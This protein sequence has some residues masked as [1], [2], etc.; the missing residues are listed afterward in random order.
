MLTLL[1]ARHGNTFDKGDIIRRVGK[2]TDLPLSQSGQLQAEQLGL[3]LKLRFA[4]IAAV[5][6]STLIRTI[7][8][9]EL[10]LK[11]MAHRCPVNNLA[12]FD[13]VDYGPDEGK[14]ESEVIARVGEQALKDWE[15]HHVVPDGWLVDPQQINRQW[16]QFIDSI[17]CEYDNKTV[18]VITSNGNARFAPD[19]A[20][21][22]STG[23]LSHLQIEKGHWQLL[24][25][26]IKPK[27]ILS[28]AYREG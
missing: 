10:A 20:V 9:A 1:I 24:E 7:Q 19:H 8:T 12:C 25:A 26:N 23:A 18:L 3:Y 4:D 15:E 22:L 14:P 6:T 5:Y 27:T 21:K 11:A 17:A 28:E 2:S 13:E 16:Q